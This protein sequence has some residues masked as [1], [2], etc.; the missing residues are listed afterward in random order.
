KIYI[1]IGLEEKEI[2]LYYN[3]L[4]KWEEIV[5][6][7]LEEDNADV[8]AKDFTKR[9]AKEVLN[10]EIEN[11]G[12]KFLTEKVLDA[13]LEEGNWDNDFTM[14]GLLEELTNPTDEFIS[15]MA[16]RLSQDYTTKDVEW[17]KERLEKAKEEG[18]LSVISR[19][20]DKGYLDIENGEQE[21]NEPEEEKEQEDND[22]EEETEENFVDNIRDVEEKN[23][24][25][26]EE[27]IKEKLEDNITDEEEKN[28]DDVEKK[29]TDVNEDVVGEEQE[30]EEGF[31]NIDNYIQ[32]VKESKGFDEKEDNEDVRDEEE[33]DDN[34][35]SIDGLI[36]SDDKEDI[37]T[38]EKDDNDGED[39]QDLLDRT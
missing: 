36:G 24:E 25:D 32:N 20:N 2:K 14:Y 5:V 8:Y 29:I 22:D 27:K 34:F 19:L 33:N 18:F 16:G 3:V 39:F 7:D 31:T 12:K 38:E 4:E 1:N 28:V 30:R 9:I 37:D 11:N 10:R 26:V 15:L 6:V 17:I 13:R 21:I 23:E 35:P